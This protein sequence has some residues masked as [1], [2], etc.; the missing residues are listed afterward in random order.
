MK[1][2]LIIDDEKD[3]GEMVQLYLESRGKYEAIA[4]TG[5]KEGLKV[6]SQKR[7]D[8]ILLDIMMP[9]MDGLEVLQK[10]KSD[11][12]TQNIPIIMLTA[13]DEQPSIK[14]AMAAYAEH[15][16]VK[17]VKLSVLEAQ[18]DRILQLIGFGNSRQEN[19]RGAR[20]LPSAQNGKYMNDGAASRQ[21]QMAAAERGKGEKKIWLIDD[22]GRVTTVFKQVSGE[23]G[24]KL[25]ENP[26]ERA[27]IKGDR[28]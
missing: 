6:A 23:E 19:R 26:E 27:R 18:I 14:Q 28:E 24:Y 12:K 21:D 8:L 10:L 7:P 5:G 17:P 20:S 4:V 9:Q 11:G 16:F 3:F 2:I 1:K 13:V 25:Q 15:Y 22:D